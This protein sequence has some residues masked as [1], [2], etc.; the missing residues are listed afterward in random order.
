[1]FQKMESPLWYKV[2]QRRLSFSDFLTRLEDPYVLEKYV[3]PI[4]VLSAFFNHDPYIEN[5][6]I[7]NKAVPAILSDERLYRYVYLYYSLGKKFS[8]D[9]T[10]EG[11]SNAGSLKDITFVFNED[12]NE[13]HLYNWLASFLHCIFVFG[14]LNKEMPVNVD[15]VEKLTQ[16]NLFISEMKDNS[17][18]FSGITVEKAYRLS[19]AHNKVK[20]VK[21]FF[22]GKRFPS[23]LKPYRDD[24]KFFLSILNMQWP[25]LLYSV[26]LEKKFTKEE[27][28]LI[29]DTST[30]IYNNAMLEF[31]LFYCSKMKELFGQE[32]PVVEHLDHLNMISPEKDAKRIREFMKC[33]NPYERK[34]WFLQRMI[35]VNRQIE[36]FAKEVENS[37]FEKA[38][39]KYLINNK[40]KLDEDIA[41]TGATLINTLSLNSQ[42]P[43]YFYNFSDMIFHMN[44]KNLYF[45][46]EDE[47]SKLENNVNPYDN[48][49]LPMDIFPRKSKNKPMTLS[50]DEMWSNILRRR[51]EPSELL[52]VEENKDKS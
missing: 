40:R 32:H 38:F 9:F 8:E 29:N 51:I 35:V 43:Y 39:T 18:R 45:F 16:A 33:L 6:H 3:S 21:E 5:V 44:E 41:M 2:F 52:T 36:S 22:L 20:E 10:L 24:R 17:F 4:F 15:E 11:I 30:V 26:N 7:I 48:Q 50:I 37:S 12:V 28:D 23:I 47:L 14:P 34:R 31:Y 25:Q 1:M 49:P 19:I 46:L 13:N 42:V 27:I